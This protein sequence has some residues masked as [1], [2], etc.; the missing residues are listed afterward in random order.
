MTTR[1]GPFT[2]R[3]FLLASLGLALA[4][5]VAFPGA[6]LGQAQLDANQQSAD[7]FNKGDYDVAIACATLAIHLNPND[8]KGYYQRGMAYQA[9]G[10]NDKAIDDLDRALKLNPNDLNAY[11]WRGDAHHAKG[12]NDKAVADYTVAI[13][14][15]A[16]P[17]FYGLVNRG[18]AYSASGRY[19]LAMTDFNH[20]ISLHPETAD[21]SFKSAYNN[22]GWL[23]ATCPQAQFR[24]GRLAVKNAKKACELTQWKDPASLDTLAA[25]CAEA[26]DFD[27]AV[28]WEKLFLTLPDI[29]PQAMMDGASRLALYQARKP[30]HVGG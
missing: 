18:I 6:V 16:V 3:R 19:A 2:T 1:P 25:A 10:E 20:A 30:Y 12:A 21:P 7:A 24:D 4:L 5:W 14:G 26:G 29:S 11:Y 15:E 13:Q 22:L 8:A 28:K 9:K 23:L 27:Q 17:P